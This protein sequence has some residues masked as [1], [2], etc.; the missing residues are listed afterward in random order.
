MKLV[1]GTYR[2][3]KESGVHLQLTDASVSRVHLTIEVLPRTVRIT[4]VGSTNGT[5]YQGQ[6]FSAVELAPPA[7]VR[8]GRTDLQLLRADAVSLEIA[9]STATHFGALVGTS[10]AMR[11]LFALLERVA[12]RSADLLLVGETGT[13]KEVCAEA[14]HRASPRATGPF[15]VAD[16]AGIAP[17]LIESELF[18]HVEGAFT[19]AD[20]A[21]EGLFEQASGGTLFLDEVGELPL[22][23]QSRLLRL[24]ER[25][26]TKRVGGDTYRQVDVRVIA[27]THRDLPERIREKQ[28]REDLYHR[29]SVITVPLPPLRDRME[30]LPL[31]V[32]AFL[33]RGGL[34]AEAMG[35]EARGRLAS[36]PWPGNVRELRNVVERVLS[37]GAIGALESFAAPSSNVGGAGD[38]R[39]P[40]KE[41]KLRLLET[42]E[43]DYVARLLLAAGGNITRAAQAAGISRVHL[44]T[45]LKKHGLKGPA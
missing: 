16:L 13:G 31:L 38:G 11:Q 23:L 4:D 20:S 24:V 26:Q 18:G 43:R 41:A 36:Y 34:G 39:M 25:R 14:I 21:R 45:L 2:V 17:S 44:Q 1:R 19:G 27:A 22:E 10:V 33:L 8:L 40:F 32:D 29:L 3:G 35:A 9:P 30:D 42:F 28:F 5:F 6:R 37:L 12:V 7:V 15:V